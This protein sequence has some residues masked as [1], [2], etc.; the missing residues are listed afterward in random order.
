MPKVL[1]KRAQREKIARRYDS[2]LRE[3][4]PGVGLVEARGTSSH[5]SS[6]SSRRATR[7]ISFCRD[8]ER[9]KSNGGELRA[10]HTLTY[11]VEILKMPRG[12]LPIAEEIGDRTISIPMYPTLSEADQDRVVDAIAAAWPR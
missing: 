5:H 11:L 12:T 3:R 4:V 2:L 9:R 10:I 1:A 8:W 7:E 6:R